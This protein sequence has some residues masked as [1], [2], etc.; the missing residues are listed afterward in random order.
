MGG[1]MCKLNKVPLRVLDDEEKNYALNE[2]KFG[3]GF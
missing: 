3:I 1:I 2:G